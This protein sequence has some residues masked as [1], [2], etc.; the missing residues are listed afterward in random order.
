MGQ[1]SFSPPVYPQAGSAPGER[2]LYAR[3]AGGH[4]H[5]ERVGADGAWWWGF[6]TVLPGALDSG[7]AAVSEVRFKTARS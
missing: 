7:A 4:A 1:V 3:R 2:R 5:E 6:D